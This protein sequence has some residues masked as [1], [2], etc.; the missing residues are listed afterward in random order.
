MRFC[1][2]DPRPDDVRYDSFCKPQPWCQATCAG[3]GFLVRKPFGTPVKLQD[4]ARG[5]CWLS[6]KISSMFQKGS[7]GPQNCTAP[8][9]EGGPWVR[10]GHTSTS[11]CGMTTLS[12][13]SRSNRSHGCGVPLRVQVL[14][15]HSLLFSERRGSS[16]IAS[17]CSGLLVIVCQHQAAE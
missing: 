9:S 13:A 16:W 7:K 6:S 12:A 15:R 2:G 1:E 4:V 10:R 3:G 11:C 17:C 5:M 14:A 8:S